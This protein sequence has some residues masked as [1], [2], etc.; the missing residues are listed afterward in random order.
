MGEDFQRSTTTVQLLLAWVRA[1]LE[2]M[3]EFLESEQADTPV[4]KARK[5]ILQNLDQELS[6]EDI[7]AHV[8]VSSGYLGRLFKR[9]T[10]M[11]LSEFIFQERMKLAARLLSQTSLYVT[12][13][14]MRV[15]FSNFPYFS[16]QFKKYS[17]M[18]PVEYRRRAEER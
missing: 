6:R 2:G 18:T 4:K 15:G 14:A 3:E 8:F 11:S 13:V 17:G 10:G 9:E 12:A 1:I 5:Y 7:A 16:T